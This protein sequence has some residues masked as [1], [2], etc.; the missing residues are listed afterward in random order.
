MVGSLGSLLVVGEG[1]LFGD[2]GRTYPAAL[3]R[4]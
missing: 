1:I 3:M 4:G 2:D